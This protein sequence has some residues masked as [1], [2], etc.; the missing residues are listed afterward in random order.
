MSPT[1]NTISCNT[2]I[3]STACNV[4]QKATW[5]VKKNEITFD[6]SLIMAKD[7]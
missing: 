1:S 5:H 2:F 6:F 7:A 3:L 4:K